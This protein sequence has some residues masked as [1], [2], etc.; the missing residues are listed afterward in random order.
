MV[1]GV[2]ELLVDDAVLDERRAHGFV[3]LLGEP[4]VVVIPDDTVGV[5]RLGDRRNHRRR[6]AVPDDEVAAEVPV[7]RP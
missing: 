3:S 2:V 1:D 4:G 5:D 7:A 6:V